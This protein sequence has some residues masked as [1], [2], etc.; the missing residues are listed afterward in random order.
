MHKTQEEHGHSK[1]RPAR[2]EGASSEVRSARATKSPSLK[3]PEF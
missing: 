1:L 3:S 2:Y